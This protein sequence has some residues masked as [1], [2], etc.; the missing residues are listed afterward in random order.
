ML[1]VQKVFLSQMFGQTSIFTVPGKVSLWQND[2]FCGN[3]NMDVSP[4][5]LK[6]KFFFKHTCFTMTAWNNIGQL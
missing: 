4:Y 5:I 2:V 3:M 6:F 1:V